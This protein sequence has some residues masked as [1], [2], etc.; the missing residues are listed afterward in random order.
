MLSGG[1]MVL[2]TGVLLA[3]RRAQADRVRPLPA[4]RRGVRRGSWPRPGVS[5]PEAMRRAAE[6][7]Q[8]PL[9]VLHRPFP[10]P[11]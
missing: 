8:L 2:T 1:E 4:P 5:P 11:S 3:W 7:C 6:R 10:S 9:V